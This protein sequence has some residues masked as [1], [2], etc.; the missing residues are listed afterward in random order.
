M[1]AKPYN[2]KHQLTSLTR[3]AQAIPSIDLERPTLNP[4]ALK[5]D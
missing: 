3:T 4:E 2:K 1:Y 5:N